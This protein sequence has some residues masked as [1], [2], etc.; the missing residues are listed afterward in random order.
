MPPH[1]EDAKRRALERLHANDGSIA[2]TSRET[3]ISSRTLRRWRDAAQKPVTNPP[4][5]THP[6]GESEDK[7][8]AGDRVAQ[9][10]PLPAD[11]LGELET[12]IAKHALKL[13]KELL[14]DDDKQ[15]K[16]PAPLNQRASALSM[17]VDKLLKLE[18]RRLHADA[19]DVNTP[20][21]QQI[22]FRDVDGKW[23]GGGDDA[24]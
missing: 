16:Q 21:V 9:D 15:K 1:S 11:V 20:I 14:L 2:Q 12:H 13:A 10:D 5:Q 19:D 3:G 24:D 22:A 17:L 18:A 23:Y 4:P 7:S 8:P 6:A